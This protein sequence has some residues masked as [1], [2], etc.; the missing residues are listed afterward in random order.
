[1]GGLV[2]CASKSILLRSRSW[3]SSSP[4]WCTPQFCSLRRCTLSMSAMPVSSPAHTVNCYDLLPAR[5]RPRSG[6]PLR[7]L[8]DYPLPT[9][10]LPSGICTST[11][12]VPH[13]CAPVVVCQ[14]GPALCLRRMR[15]RHTRTDIG[16]GEAEGAGYLLGYW[17][18]PLSG[19]TVQSKRRTEYRIAERH[20]GTP[21]NGARC[22]VA[23]PRRGS[24]STRVM[25]DCVYECAL[26]TDDTHAGTRARS[27]QPGNSDGLQWRGGDTEDEFRRHLVFSIPPS[28]TILRHRSLSST[29]AP[30]PALNRQPDVV[31]PPR[32]PPR[33]FCAFSRPRPPPD[34]Q[35]QIVHSRHRRSA[36]SCAGVHDIVTHDSWT[37]RCSSPPG[38]VLHTVELYLRVRP[39][40]LQKFPPAH[41]VH[42][43]C[44]QA[45]LPALR[46]G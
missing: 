41:A 23:P 8:P 2:G 4:H 31:L 36:A 43:S 40:P 10:P 29:Y 19:W 33:P 30:V 3:P 16:G 27:A 1:M 22:W 42:L 7:L 26:R 24:E 17:E 45:T 20:G 46:L 37:R 28:W 25:G 34:P 12:E 14:E 6:P 21:T 5:L 38:F 32:P 13:S 44:S 9:P 11:V 18:K 35:P 39:R 15:R